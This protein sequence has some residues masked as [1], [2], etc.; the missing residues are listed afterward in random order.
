ME[1]DS[2]G[3]G[4]KHCQCDVGGTEKRDG[5]MQI[6]DKDNGQCACKRGMTGRYRVFT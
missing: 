6:C 1:K 5:R 4:C 3:F 2:N